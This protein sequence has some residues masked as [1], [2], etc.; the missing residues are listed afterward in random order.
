MCRSWVL[1]VEEILEMVPGS[2]SQ[3]HQRL[4]CLR[5]VSSAAKPRACQ[6]QHILASH[7]VR[8]ATEGISVGSDDREAQLKRPEINFPSYY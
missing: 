1:I 5:A 8:T 3:V 6:S 4:N 2:S 7:Y